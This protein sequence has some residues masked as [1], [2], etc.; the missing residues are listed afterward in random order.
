MHELSVTESLVDLCRREAEKNS[1]RKVKRV[2]I[3]LGRFTGFSRDSI[4]FYFEILRPN[5]C[6]EEAKLKFREIPIIIDCKKCREQSEIGEPILICPRC[7]NAD[8]ELRSGR[9]FYVESIEGE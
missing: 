8:I 7:G 2:N 6:L 9:E 1:I 3:A 5:S 4:R